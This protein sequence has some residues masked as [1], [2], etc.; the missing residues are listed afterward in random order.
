MGN[1]AFS[2]VQI[3]AHNKKSLMLIWALASL[4]VMAGVCFLDLTVMQTQ[5]TSNSMA[6]SE[7]DGG[8]F[9]IGVILISVTVG[10]MLDSPKIALLQFLSSLYVILMT[11][12]LMGWG[13]FSLN[14]QSLLG[15]MVLLTV[16]S[17][18]LVHILSTLAREM[19]RG[20]FQ[21][22]AVAEALK[23]NTTP[24]FLS[25]FTT[26]LGFAVL[27][28][29][30]SS[31]ADMIWLVVLGVTISF[32]TTLSWLPMVL[33]SWLLEFRVGNTR[34]R[35][36]LT[37]LAKWLQK[38]VSMRKIIVFGGLGIALVLLA[39]FWNQVHFSNQFIIMLAVF[40]LI[41]TL[42][43]QSLSLAAIN[44]FMNLLALLLAF[45]LFAWFFE[46]DAYLALLWLVPLG[47]I[48]DD[49]IHFFSRYVRA[50]QSVFADPENSV[51]YAMASVAQPIWITS[52]V[53]VVAMVVLMFSQNELIFHAAVLTLI[54]VVLTAFI[55]LLL[56]PALLMSQRKS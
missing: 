44:L 28:W 22:D 19:A 16:M 38:H 43:W 55:V 46:V 10:L 49:G 31:Y 15:L 21:Y 11:F 32:L 50:K 36:G 8:L 24:I 20:L 30:D 47:I 26:A 40:A 41:F 14:S 25:N 18:N 4:L 54:A 39:F 35:H 34:D 9:F 23:L 17:S 51:I 45:A 5:S 48:I 56:L 37:F 6:I 42:A 12:G 2:W 13:N 27:F 52:W 53:L 7:L 33:L 1:W 29:V 3:I